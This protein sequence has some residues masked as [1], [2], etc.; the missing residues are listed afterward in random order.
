M[1]A[2]SHSQYIADRDIPHRNGNP[3]ETRR[4]CI[5]KPTAQTSFRRYFCRVNWDLYPVSARLDL[6][7]LT[8]IEIDY[9]RLLCIFG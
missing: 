2:L 7:A 8:H 9:A 4:F 5:S 3:A 6:K 1:E